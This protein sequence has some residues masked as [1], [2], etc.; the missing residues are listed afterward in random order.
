MRVQQTLEIASSVSVVVAATVLTW[1]LTW[2]QPNTTR[3][4]RQSAITDVTG[5]QL[6]AKLATNITG[7]GRVAIVEFADFQCPF[8]A[9]Y[10]R[11]TWPLLRRQFIATNKARYV[12]L[13]YPLETIH[14]LALAAS[15]ASECAALQGRYW[16]MR[17]RLYASGDAL[18]PADIMSHVEAIDL[19]KGQFAACLESDVTLEKIRADQAEAKRL[20]VTGTPTFFIGVV[21]VDGDIELVKRLQG[22][23]PSD[24][25]A[26]ELQRMLDGDVKLTRPAGGTM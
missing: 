19:D 8:C 1:T 4:A 6:P 15:E 13:N 23:L 9:Q 22:A 10:V 2:R 18:T 24:A 11:G 7:G 5:A 21:N 12:A 3:A 17:E 26:Q 16:Q 25:F 20:G 14:P